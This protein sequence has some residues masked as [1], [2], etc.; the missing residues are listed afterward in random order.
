MNITKR[1]AEWVEAGA[2]TCMAHWLLIVGSLL[3]FASAVLKWVYFAFSR[4][5]SGFELPLLGKM[6][7]IPVFSVLSYGVIGIAVLAIALVLVWRSAT[8]LALC[9]VTVLVAMWLAVP[10]RLA[11][12]QPSLLRRLTTETQ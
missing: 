3:V 5:P 8:Y 11:F 9:A 7:L 4:H 1:L 12:S 2:R 10:C 6:E